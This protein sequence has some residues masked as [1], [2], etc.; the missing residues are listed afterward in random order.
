MK[1]A[2]NSKTKACELVCGF[3]RKEANAWANHLYERHFVQKINAFLPLHERNN[4]LG[5]HYENYINQS[6]NTQITAINYCLLPCDFSCEAKVGFPNPMK[7]HHI[8]HFKPRFS[9]EYG[10]KL[11]HAQPFICPIEN[12]NYVSKMRN[13]L[14]D[15]CF[16]KQHNVMEKYY[17]EYPKR[18]NFPSLKNGSVFL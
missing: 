3:E 13:D 2:Q 10:S 12:C 16:N 17:N 5:K 11:N 14:L 8:K 4:I 18:D 15:H 7:R 6:K 1:P 9:K